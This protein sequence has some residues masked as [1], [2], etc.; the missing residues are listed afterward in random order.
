MKNGQILV[1]G[2]AGFIGSALIKFLLEQNN[3]VTVFDNFSVTN[4]LKGIKSDNLK[5]IRG[6]LTS[7]SDLKKIPSKIDT[8]FHLAADPEVRLTVTNPRSIFQNNVLATYNLLEWLRETQV[9]T[10]VF[11][12]TSAVY[13][14][15]STIPTPESYPCIPI[16]LYGASKLACESLLS[17]YCNTYKK[18]G[19]AIRLAN[20]VGSASTHGIIFDMIKK[21]KKN[22]TELEILGDGNQNKSYLYIDDCIS[23][24]IHLAEK[25]NSYFDVYNLGSDTQVTVKEIIELLLNELG[26]SNVNKIFTGGVEGGRGWVG[27]VKKMLLDI[28]KMKSTGWRPKLNSKDAIRKTLCS[29]IEYKKV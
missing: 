22:P 25:C 26:Y 1:T 20:V 18:R 11:T 28:D 15:A 17:A 2:G 12:S 16:S 13:G 3:K 23:G 27:D 29:T 7:N 8:V 6:D 4:N 5:I 19:V 9:K 10:I 14:D 24:I 21:L